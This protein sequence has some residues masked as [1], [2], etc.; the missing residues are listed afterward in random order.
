[1]GFRYT[2]YRFYFH[3]IYDYE[4]DK[5]AGVKSISHENY[6]WLEYAHPKYRLYKKIISSWEASHHKQS[7]PPQQH[8]EKT[9]KTFEDNNYVVE[10]DNHYLN[11]KYFEQNY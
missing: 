9:F 2:I 10:L 1:M 4:L 8:L 5:W 6:S 11:F 7:P 3:E